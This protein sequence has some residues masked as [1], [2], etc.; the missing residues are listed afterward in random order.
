[1]KDKNILLPCPFCGG[2]AE[3][4]KSSKFYIA[5]TFFI[6][7]G[8]IYCNIRPKTEWK[9]TKLEAIKAWNERKPMERIMEQ[10]QAVESLLDAYKTPPYGIEVQGTVETLEKIVEIIKKGKND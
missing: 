1:M 4:C 10:L 9:E 3:I 7:C 8:N 5:D 2:D 6:E